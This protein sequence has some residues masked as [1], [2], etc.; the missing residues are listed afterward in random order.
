MRRSRSDP[1]GVCDRRCGCGS[2]G[3]RQPVS[4]FR[5]PLAQKEFDMKRV[6]AM[7]LAVSFAGLLGCEQ[8]SGTAP[9]TDPNKPDAVRKITLTLSGDHTVTQGETDEV[10]VN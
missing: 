5:A 6:F 1:R 3:E 7:A 9:S 2:W 4:R 8:K 10:L